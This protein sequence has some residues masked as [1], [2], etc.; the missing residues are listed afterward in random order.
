MYVQR[1]IEVRLCSHC[2]SGKAI[3][4]TYSECV[5]VT[6]VI[7]HAMSMRRILVPP[8]ASPALLYITVIFEKRYDFLEKKVLNI[9]I[10]LNFSIILSE[11]FSF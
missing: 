8:V 10:V 1:D 5:F 2:C 9:K 3:T 11:K 4:V 7:Q 6:L